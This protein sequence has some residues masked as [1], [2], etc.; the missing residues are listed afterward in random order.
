[1][2]KA[3]F[4]TAI[5][6][7]FFSSGC[8]KDFL[9]KTPD[10]DLTIEDVFSQ[11]RYA[12]SFLTSVYAQ[13]P[14]E[15]NMSDN[16]GRNPFVAAT[17]EMNITWAYAFSHAMVSGAWGPSN[18]PV[19][20]WSFM[21][22]GIR[23]ANIFLENVDNVPLSP[24]VFTET[25]RNRWI[26][27]AT[28]LR[29]FYHFMLMRVHGPVPIADHSFQLTDDFLELRRRPLE[30][31]VAFVVTESER[32]AELL[33][34]RVASNSEYGRITRA[35]ALALKARVL[36]YAASPLWNGNPDY[37][38]FTDHEGLRLFPTA[39]D[40]EKWYRAYVAA[41][42]CIDQTETGGY[43][44]FRLNNSDPAKA[45]QDLFLLP[46][47]NEIFFARNIGPSLLFERSSG[48]LS[49]GGFSAYA[50]TQ[51]IV[52]AYEMANGERPILGYNGDDSPIINP[53]SG[54][55][56]S[57]YTTTAHPSGHYPAGVHN[58][59]AN[60]EPRF[61]AHIHFSGSIWRDRQIQ[62]WRTGLD[63]RGA[64]GQNYTS[65]GYLIKKFSDPNVDVPANRTV[66]KTWVLFRLGE[67]YL[68]YAEA[69]N[70]FEG[71][72]AD[73]YTYVNQIRK[74]AG[75]PPLPD[76]L[77]QQEMRER[78]RHERRIELAFETHRYFD[79]RRWKIAETVDNKDVFGMNIQ[80][81]T[82]LQDNAF[83]QRTRVETRIFTAPKH[84]LWPLY[85]S[86][87][88]KN[89]NLV[90]NPQW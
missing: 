2:N 79:V 42:D 30:E 38:R 46:Y 86:E 11:H 17:D 54:Y 39:Y 22:E 50:P 76:G 16:P 24:P 14:D 43:E 12:E 64:G 5:S 47:N 71:P 84:Y 26:G 18:M 83:Y 85:Q 44:I 35:V 10:E 89:H 57:G 61:Y 4:L 23:K 40:A 77:T 37:A 53:A 88:D 6:F 69:L 66:L 36:L 56:E 41:K 65:T 20:I 34:I 78:I 67:Q 1:M 73:V 82:S 29:A 19:N 15:S 59:Y 27:E 13:L 80:G 25:V 7:I 63:G 62:F 32:A 49:H 81:G 45:C 68:N 58:M 55:S 74:R 87:I 60:R 90:Q 8:Q 3:L 75:M 33:P 72:V 51:E 31:C 52:D 9:D 48:P 21:Y 28:F 70:E